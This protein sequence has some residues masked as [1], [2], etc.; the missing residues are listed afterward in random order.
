[1]NDSSQSLQKQAVRYFSANIA[2]FPRTVPFEK[3]L[4]LPTIIF[5]FNSRHV[6]EPCLKGELLRERLKNRVTFKKIGRLLI[7]ALPRVTEN[8]SLDDEPHDLT[9][10]SAYHHEP[11]VSKVT[12]DGKVLGVPYSSMNLKRFVGYFKGG[13]CREEFRNRAFL[14]DRASGVQESCRVKH[15]QTGSVK[16]DRHVRNLEADTFKVAYLSSKLFS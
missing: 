1:M 6:G 12:F 4:A 5:D 8:L 9:R 7:L 11:R 10:P 2:V 3:V 14:A 16:F 13:L 15:E